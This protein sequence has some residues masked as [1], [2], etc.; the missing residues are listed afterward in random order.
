MFSRIHSKLGTAGLIVAVVA[1]VAALG[2]GA[3]AANN[4]LNGKQKNEV[5]KLAKKFAGKRGA[6]GAK[7][8]KGDPGDPGTPGTNGLPGDP[9]EKGGKGDNGKSATVTEVACGGIG[10]AEV[11]VEGAAEGVEVCNGEDGAPWAAGGVLPS[12]ETLTGVWNVGLAAGESA[13]LPISFPI[14]LEN[15]PE[16]IYVEGA[17]TAG[18]PGLTEGLP[19]ADPGKLCLY[20]FSIG[21]GPIEGTAF[22][23][24]FSEEAGPEFG[25]GPSGTVLAIGCEEAPNTEPCAL[26][27]TWAVT[28]E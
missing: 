3:Y 15:A 23:K 20:N 17:S 27:G 10:G 12:E 9:G 25:A 16:P 22:F 14:P 11:K 4:G 7:G 2:G 19:T 1:L 26:V 24:P 5:K 13:Q 18:C 8:A 6:K 21:T 28:A